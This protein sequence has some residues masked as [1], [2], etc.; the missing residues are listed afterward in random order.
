MRLGMTRTQARHAY[1]H[2]SNR[3]KKYEDFF[4]LTPIGVRVGYA[5]PAELHA[6]P[7]SERA[8]LEDRV[9]WAP[10]S[11]AYYTVDGIR[12][13]AT[14]AAAKAALKL[15]APFQIGLNT[16]Y[17]AT[18]HGSTAILK[19]GRRIVEEIGIA[20]SSLTGGRKRERAFLASFS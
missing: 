5:S 20:A 14:V 12:A 18:G 13:G 10:T 11:S 1:T 19:V 8:K 16:W 6:L 15:E 17:V 7:K 4:C 2:S 3:G 9:I